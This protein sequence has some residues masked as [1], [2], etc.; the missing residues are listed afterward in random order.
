MTT[1]RTP[2]QQQGDDLVALTVM[3]TQATKDAI[4][5]LARCDR[6]SLSQV[7]RMALEA[8]VEDRTRARDV[9]V[10]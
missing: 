2:R 3:V 7:G 10:E 1:A 5:R 9:T 6:R 4:G 8:Y